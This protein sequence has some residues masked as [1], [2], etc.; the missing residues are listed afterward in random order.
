M[1][2]GKWLDSKGMI[3]ADASIPSSRVRY[4]LHRISKYQ[5]GNAFRS[6]VLLP[7]SGVHLETHASAE[8][9]V[10]YATKLLRAF[11]QDPARLYVRPR[12]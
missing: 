3:P 8:Q 12:T 4:V 6:P 10:A 7:Q 5:R 9:V 11:G 2:T 1:E